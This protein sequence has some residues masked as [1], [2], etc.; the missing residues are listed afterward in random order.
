MCPN[1]A[2]MMVKMQS[3]FGHTASSAERRIGREA[4]Q[5]YC[6]FYAEMKE[7]LR[8]LEI[9]NKSDDGFFYSRRI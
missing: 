3:S 4:Y 7:D 2:V 8:R 9:L 6:I 5:S 1:A